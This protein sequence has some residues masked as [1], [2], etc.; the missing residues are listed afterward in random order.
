MSETPLIN[1][2]TDNSKDVKKT[3]LIGDPIKKREFDLYVLWKSLPYYFK[4]PP[5]I[6]NRDGSY[7]SQT[8][9]QF[10]D[11]LGI[12][13]EEIVEL[14]QLKNQGQFAERYNVAPETLSDWNKVIK[15]R[16]MLSDTRAWA[17]KLSK[18][19][20]LA[21]YNNA[22]SSKNLNADRDRA[23]FLKYGGWVEKTA[24]EIDAGETLAGF[25][26]EALKKP[27]TNGTGDS[28]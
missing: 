1:T 17:L 14:S 5:S 2:S 9:D 8:T 7:T 28:A 15:T 26:M 25:I 21:M 18:N 13:D 19:V 24:H 12:D 20:V 27:K 22:L 4:R 10:L 11:S 16:D 23:N 6:K 3:G